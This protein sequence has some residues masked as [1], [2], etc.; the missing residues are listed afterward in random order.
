M[1]VSAPCIYQVHAKFKKGIGALEQ[2]LPPE[3]A[4]MCELGFKPKSSVRTVNAFKSL[5]FEVMIVLSSFSTFFLVRHTVCSGRDTFTYS[6][7]A[8]KS[9]HFWI[10][11]TDSRMLYSSSYI[12]AHSNL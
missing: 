10:K 11:R 6:S 4:N 1:S 2:E 3:S 8:N 7:A 12:H 5:N 9:V